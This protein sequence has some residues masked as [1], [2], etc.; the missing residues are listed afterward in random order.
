MK[1]KNVQKRLKARQD[2][3]ETIKAS[4]SKGPNKKTLYKPS[5]GILEYTKPGS[6]KKKG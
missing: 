3:W 6:L 4:E 2:E 5:G 1:H